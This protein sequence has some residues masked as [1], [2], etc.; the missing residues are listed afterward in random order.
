MG[1]LLR[2]YCYDYWKERCHDGHQFDGGR[3]VSYVVKT[4]ERKLLLVVVPDPT[5]EIF[6]IILRTHFL[7]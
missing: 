7:P 1:Y 6:L 5:E 3:V 2:L 4:S